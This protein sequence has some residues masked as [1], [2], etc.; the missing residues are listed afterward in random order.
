M[1]MEKKNYIV[2]I[3][4]G[5]SNVTVIVG[6]KNDS[7][8]ISVEAV[9]S[10]PS[11]GVN[12]GM[13]ENINQVSEV[14]K[15]AKQEVEE[16]LG[17]RIGEAYAGLSGAFV[18][19]ARYSDH[20]FVQEPQEGISKRDVDA[21]F[22]RMQNV[23]APDDE[24]IMER[25]PQN[26]MVDGG[27]EIKNP[28]GS[29]GRQLTST[30]DFILC[31]KTPLERLKMVFRHSGIQLAGVYANSLIVSEAVLSDEEKEEGVAVVDIGGGTTDVAVYH[32]NVL[33][34]VATVPM[35]A[36]S[37]NRD[38]HLHGV[39]ERNVENL[40][41]KYGS[42][43]AEFVSEQKLIQIPSMGHR[44]KGVL[45]RNLAAIIEA[46]LTDIA[47]Y[48]K[49]ELR[50]SE[51]SKRLQF[52]I[53]LTGGSALLE[54]IDELFRRVTGLDVRVATA[55][56]GIDEES[57]EKIASPAH[58][59]AVA[60]LLQGA[61]NGFCT[62][63]PRPAAA[64]RTTVPNTAAAGTAA[65]GAASNSYGAASFGRQPF[66]GAQPKPSPAY[67]P[68]A[69]PKREEPEISREPVAEDA[70]QTAISADG[71]NKK[72]KHDTSASRSGWF[73]RALKGTTD[74]INKFFV[75]GGEDEEL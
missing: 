5:S 50:D 72:D 15:A 35:G 58:T 38:I 64:S 36:N 45:R 32:G 26:Y 20:V 43:V 8:P 21:L 61:R 44:T 11:V 30:F 56:T 29:F 40:K 52:G 13:I 34:Y 55:D 28:V 54:H 74:A 22:E 59:A 39:P 70:P 18:R 47:E 46:R 16:E 6:S 14:L 75:E 19:C 41:K 69:E 51:Y 65:T 63:T 4:I 10:K 17:I 37:I 48:V 33:R 24:V 31:E 66:A 3:D 2:G 27:Q 1:N 42:A 9:V 25:I 23:V 62:V 12:A 60:L 49:A 68:V 67:R 73:S 57:C 53:V 71:V 7:D